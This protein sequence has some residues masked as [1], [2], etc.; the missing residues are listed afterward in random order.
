MRGAGKFQPAADHR[1]LQ[2]RDDRD[3]AVLDAVEHPVP[4]LRVQEPAGGVVL[5]QFGEI[6]AGGE[7]VADAVDDDCAEVVGQ[8]GETL[9]DFENDAVIERIALGGPVETHGQHRAPPL[10]REVGSLAGAAS[11]FGVSHGRHCVLFR[12]VMLYNYWRRSQ[13]ASTLPLVAKSASSKA[14]P[15]ALERW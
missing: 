2:R 7:M 11:G 8:A 4:H 14:I 6:E 3:A 9:A 15:P 1:S 10:D 13:Q 5:G 12:I